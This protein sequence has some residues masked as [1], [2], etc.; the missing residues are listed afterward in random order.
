M[1]DHINYKMYVI[2]NFS[3]ETTALPINI[4]FICLYV[5]SNVYLQRLRFYLQFSSA[6]AYKMNRR[7]CDRIYRIFQR[8]YTC[9]RFMF[10]DYRTLEGSIILV[11][12]A[13]LKENISALAW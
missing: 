8:N 3:N 1:D 4:S 11:G 13:A 6:I 12:S 5:S 2:G 7:Y 9:T 10:I